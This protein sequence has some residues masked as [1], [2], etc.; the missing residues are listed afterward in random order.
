MEGSARN[1]RE[2]FA[3]KIVSSYGALCLT[4]YVSQDGIHEDVCRQIYSDAGWR[5]LGP[6]AVVYP[7]CWCGSW[8]GRQ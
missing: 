5:R 8:R 7:A 3:A 2:H 6:G 1:E 4:G